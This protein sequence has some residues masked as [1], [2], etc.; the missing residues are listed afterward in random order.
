[1]EAMR[2]NWTDSR[3]D[4]LKDQVDRLDSKFDRQTPRSTARARRGPCA[5][6][7]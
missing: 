7:L 4:D 3:M 1:M 6:M 2:Q 5:S